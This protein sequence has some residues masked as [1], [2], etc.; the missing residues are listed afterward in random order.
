MRTADL[1]VLHVTWSLKTGGLEHLVVDLVR[2]GP[3]M[4][5]KPMVA[6]LAQCGQLAEEVES[7]GAP[8]FSLGKRLGLDFR[9]VP[10]LRR[11]IARHK[12]QVVHAHNQGAMLYAS[13]AALI[14]GRPMVATRHGTSR[15]A[16]DKPADLSYRLLSHLMG[17]LARY[18]VCV[19]RDSLRVAREVDHIPDK[20]LCLIYNGVDPAKFP[21]GPEVRARARQEL[22]LDPGMPLIVHVG[23]LSP[24]KDQASLLQACAR[25]QRDMDDFRLIILGDGD[26]REPLQALAANLGLSGQVRMP[27][28]R[29]DVWRYLASADV[30][31]LS[32]LSEGISI[33]LLEAMA[34]QLPVVATR[35]GGNPEVVK[36]GESGL[37][38]PPRNPEALAGALKRVLQD[39]ALARSLGKAAASRVAG[40]FSLARMAADYAALYREAAAGK[41]VRP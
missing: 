40:R 5:L 7:L 6:V 38:V 17:R 29:P 9:M 23:R 11:I 30:F 26:Q 34:A 2:L 21:H 19:G 37:L 16:E 8:L 39:S 31:A 15:W 25:L 22:E 10:R 41:G 4:G 27:G 28:S 24:E 13:L 35:V 3:E 14:S 1:N 36:D 32:S 12:V 33:S 20:R 18:T